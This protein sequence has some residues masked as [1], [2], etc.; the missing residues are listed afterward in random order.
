MT[1]VEVTQED[2]EKGHVGARYCMVAQA[3]R[4]YV[5]SDFQ[6]YVGNTIAFFYDCDLAFETVKLP[7]DTLVKIDEFDN[8]K[9]LN[10]NAPTSFSFLV[11][12]PEKFLAT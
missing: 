4:K 6:V 12:I 10:G 11:D 3:L 2:I 8:W 1:L 9:N 7:W 5:N